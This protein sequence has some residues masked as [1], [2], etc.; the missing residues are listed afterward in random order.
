MKVALYPLHLFMILVFNKAFVYLLSYEISEIVAVLIC[1][2][3]FLLRPSYF[4]SWLLPI[5]L[6][7]VI[8]E[9]ISNRVQPVTFKYLLLNIFTLIECIWFVWLLKGLLIS[10]KRKKILMAGCFCLFF[11]G[12]YNLCLGQG[13]FVYNQYTRIANSLLV[14]AACLLVIW[15]VAVSDNN[16]LRVTISALMP[17]TAG[18]LLFYCGNFILYLSFPLLQRKYPSDAVQLYKAINHNLNIIEYGLLAVGLVI[19]FIS[20]KKMILK[21]K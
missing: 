20:Q 3:L 12:V 9:Q 21:S 4:N 2:V 15:E 7:T 8:V 16:K 13:L 6:A 14:T 19:E 17:I 5:L 11:F 10:L 18:L 1:T